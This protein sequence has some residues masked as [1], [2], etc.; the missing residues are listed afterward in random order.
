MLQIARVLRAAEI[1]PG[2]TLAEQQ[3][4]EAV[5]MQEAALQVVAE[6]LVLRLLV[7]EALRPVAEVLLLLELNIPSL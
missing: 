6:V 2:E 4:P 5:E 1:P 7:G 3:T